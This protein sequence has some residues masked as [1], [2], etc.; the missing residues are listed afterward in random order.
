MAGQRKNPI[1]PY[2][3]S[4]H[5]MNVLNTCERK[6][7]LDRMLILPKQADYG[8][9]VPLVR[10]NAFGIGVQ[11][12]VLHGDMDRACYDLWMA[13][14]PEVYDEQKKI[15]M[16]RTINNLRCCKDE[17][18]KLRR[19]YQVAMFN[20]QPAIE[21]SFRLDIDGKWYY[22]GYIDMV[23]Y[24]TVLDIYVVFEIK[25]TAYNLIDLKPLYKNSGQALGYSIVIDQIVGEKQSKYG[26][27]Y[28]VCRD[29]QGENFVPDIY[30]F[31][32]TKTL[33]D[34]LRWFYTVGLDVQRLNTMLDNDLFPMR[35]GACV[36][37][38]RVCPHY[39][40][41]SLT[42]SDVPREVVEDE[43][44]YQFRYQLD[45][46]IQDHLLRVQAETIQLNQANTVQTLDDLVVDLDT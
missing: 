25:T 32:F 43:T 4:E 30:T 45:D 23:L 6:F 15:Y 19:R 29:K 14:H 39:G 10:G 5:A 28:F 13:Y 36:T 44:P 8:D 1:N 34:R 2:R 20:G 22:V 24:D 12:Y 31:P 7:Q 37:F 26:V 21:L 9:S 33:L 41:C 35:G 27:V 3:L 17:L 42:S 46:V 11:S 18:D 16:W 38:N 40:T